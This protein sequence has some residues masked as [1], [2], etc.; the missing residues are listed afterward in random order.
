LKPLVLSQLAALGEMVEP[1][2]RLVERLESEGVL[3]VGGWRV[4]KRGSVSYQ[5]GR[6]VYDCLA[7]RLAGAASPG[8]SPQSES[9]GPP[10]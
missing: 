7:I 4:V 5:G 6:V 3:L 2:P 1:V 8:G 10:I 9:R